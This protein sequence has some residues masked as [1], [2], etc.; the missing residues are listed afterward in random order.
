MFGKN[1][2]NSGEYHTLYNPW[3]TNR[4][5]PGG[6]RFLAG[7]PITG[8]ISDT[9]VKKPIVNLYQLRASREGLNAAA[10][11]AAAQSG[12]SPRPDV[13]ARQAHKRFR[14]ERRRRDQGQI[15]FLFAASNPVMGCRV[16]FGS[17]QPAKA[18]AP[19]R[20]L[21]AMRRRSASRPV[22]PTIIARKVA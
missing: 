22:L 11:A 7:Y 20:C 15:L 12:P 5:P 3:V 2:D 19:A 9:F 17:R 18:F 21:R 16:L 10:A 13:G 4:R 6:T 1:E 14:T 8:P